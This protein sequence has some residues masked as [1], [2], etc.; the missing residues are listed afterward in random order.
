MKLFRRFW[1]DKVSLIL[2]V[3]FI[4]ALIGYFTKELN[5]TPLLAGFGAGYI[6][7]RINEKG[8]FFDKIREEYPEVAVEIG[9]PS[10]FK[11][12]FFYGIFSMVI[13]I[14]ILLGTLFMLGLVAY[15]FIF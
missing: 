11:K 8:K 6:M 1:E 15:K 2:F 7:F 13:N 10:I 12:P 3:I 14:I 9:I 5:V 4:L